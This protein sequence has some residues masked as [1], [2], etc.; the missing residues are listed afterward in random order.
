VKVLPYGSNSKLIISSEIRT[1]EY[2]ILNATTTDGTKEL[3]TYDIRNVQIYFEYG[4]DEQT[5]AFVFCNEVRDLISETQ[6]IRNST[7]NYFIRKNPKR[8]SEI[9]CIIDNTTH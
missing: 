5:V 2:I 9:H 6:N 8:Y 7:N 3:T 1:T 4:S